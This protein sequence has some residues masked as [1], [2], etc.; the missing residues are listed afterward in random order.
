[1]SIMDDVAK[2]NKIKSVLAERNVKGWMLAVYLGVSEQTVSGWCQNAHQPNKEYF[3]KIAD[4]LNV[5][6]RELIVSTT[7]S[8]NNF[9]EILKDAHKKFLAEGNDT[10]STDNSKGGHKGKKVLNPDLIKLLN[11]LIE[12]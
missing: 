7:P 10:Y 2:L 4:F 5:D 9:L 8:N 11:K 1:M 3:R 6:Q 12:K